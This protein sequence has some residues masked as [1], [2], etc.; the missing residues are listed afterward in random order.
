LY[1]FIYLV[2]LHILFDYFSYRATKIGHRTA[3]W[4][5]WLLIKKCW[6]TVIVI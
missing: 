2:K 3:S 1:L 4:A 6:L 5:L